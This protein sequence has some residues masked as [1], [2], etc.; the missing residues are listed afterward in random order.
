MPFLVLLLSLIGVFFVAV[1]ALDE[2]AVNAFGGIPR[3]ANRV[4]YADEAFIVRLEG[5]GS[6]TS[7]RT[8]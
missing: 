5:T 8:E 4:E 6:C 1:D 7:T 2:E 3:G